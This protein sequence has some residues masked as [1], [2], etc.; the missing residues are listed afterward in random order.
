MAKKDGIRVY[1]TPIAFRAALETRLRRDTS[2]AGFQ[3]RRQ[4]F[5]FGRLIARLLAHFGEN[6]VV[7]GGL[8][9]ELRLERARTTKDIDLVLFGEP[10][11]LLERLQ[12]AGQLDL[13][14]FMSFEVS[15]DGDIDGEGVLYGG[16]HFK[17]HCKLGGQ[18]YLHFPI[19][20]VFGGVMLGQPSTV[21]YRDDLSFAGIAPP[22]VKLLPIPTHVAEKVH[23]YT[24]PRSTTNFRVRDLPDLALLATAAEKLGL[25]TLRDALLLTFTARNTHPVPRSLPAP[26]TTWEGV[27]ANLA[28]ENDLDWGTLAEVFAAAEL[29]LRPVLEGEIDATW[30]P[31]AWRWE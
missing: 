15:P 31:T 11:Q 18:T 19:D 14:D 28:S 8:A 22:K 6:V 21:E 17:I 10:G 26:P 9:L 3:R 7:K 25:K 24:L 1:A 29:F 4:I 13:K 20:V 23:A 27:Y 5:V 12:A 16:H 30:N 2:G